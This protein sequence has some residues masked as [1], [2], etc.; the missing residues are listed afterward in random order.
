MGM[1]DSECQKG[2]SVLSGTLFILKLYTTHKGLDHT[3]QV[4]DYDIPSLE[5]VLNDRHHLAIQ[6]KSKTHY[7]HPYFALTYRYRL[8]VNWQ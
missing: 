2:L 4:C 7:Q 5:L 1:T 6:P 8:M 3:Q